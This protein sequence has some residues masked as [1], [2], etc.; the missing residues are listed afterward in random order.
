MR[1]ARVGF[2]ELQGECLRLGRILE[3]VNGG[4]VWMIQAGENMCFPLE[5][6]GAIPIEPE[7]RWQGFEGNVAMQLGVAG[8]IDLTHTTGT[9]RRLDGVRANLSARG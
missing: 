6:G 8:A 7:H 2:D 5:P 9:D 3:P 1:S 4:D